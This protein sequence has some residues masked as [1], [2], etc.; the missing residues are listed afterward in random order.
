MAIKNKDELCAAWAMVT[1]I[2]KLEGF[3]NYRPYKDGYSVQ[4]TMAWDLYHSAGV[5]LTPCGIEEMKLFQAALPW[6]QLV[7]VSGAI[8]YKGPETEKPIYLCYHSG[9]YD[10]ITSMPAFLGRAYFCLKCE[11]G[12][13]T[14]DWAHRPC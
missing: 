6:Y 13:N 9:H 10:V 8:I 5:P 14:E 12:D 7:V 3:P 11:K 1:A 2:A 4:R